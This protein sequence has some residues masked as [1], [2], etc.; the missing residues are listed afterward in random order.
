[1]DSLYTRLCLGTL[2][3]PFFSLV[4]LATGFISALLLSLS[5]EESENSSSDES[6][7]DESFSTCHNKKRMNVLEGINDVDDN[8]QTNT[9]SSS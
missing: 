1:M 9:Y 4:F 5:E 7:S 6:S 8:D 2:N 3:L